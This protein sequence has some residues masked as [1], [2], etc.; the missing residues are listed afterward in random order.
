AEFGIASD[1]LELFDVD[2]RIDVFFH[3]ALTD[4]NRV[5]EVVALPRHEGHDRVLAESDLTHVRSG[6]VR[7]HVADL[8]SLTRANDRLLIVA[9]ALIGALKLHQSVDV[10]NL[11][12]LAGIRANHD[13]RR[14]HA[15]HH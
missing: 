3:D 14:I 1:A 8:N 9:G 13:A 11:R 4:E 10:R 2:R 12:T 6:T 5:L 7:E 15:L